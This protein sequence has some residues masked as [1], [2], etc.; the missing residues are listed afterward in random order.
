MHEIICRL[1]PKGYKE[2]DV[3]IA[4]KVTINYQY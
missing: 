4:D 1:Y 3:D 2:S